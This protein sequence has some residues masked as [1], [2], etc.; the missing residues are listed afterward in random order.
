MVKH[1]R[2]TTQYLGSYMLIFPVIYALKI[3]FRLLF[4]FYPL[5]I[6]SLLYRYQKLEEERF[7]REQEY[8]AA[9]RRE[10]RQHELTM[11]QMLLAAT[12][13]TA[14]NT[15]PTAFHCSNYPIV[16]GP[17]AE[18]MHYIGAT[19]YTNRDDDNDFFEL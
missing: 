2:H 11:M 7:M 9:Q 3:H 5:M 12:Q 19:T 8:R 1:N 18:N 6:L 10:E 16:P 17:N 15:I 14:V 13:N 4:S